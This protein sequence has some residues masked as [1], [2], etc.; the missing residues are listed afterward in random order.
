MPGLFWRSILRNN[1]RS[2]RSAS[3]FG[4]VLY[5]SALALDQ[6]CGGRG[7]LGGTATLHNNRSSLC[8]EDE[9]GQWGAVA[10]KIA[11]WCIYLFGRLHLQRIIASLS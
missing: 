5:R 9:V 4:S 7:G 8:G 6:L 1:F 3:S 11:I 10:N 2:R